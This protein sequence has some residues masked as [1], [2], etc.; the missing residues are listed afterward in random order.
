MAFNVGDGSLSGSMARWPWRPPRQG[1]AGLD[2]NVSI[3][4]YFPRD[5]K[6]PREGESVQAGGCP[7]QPGQAEHAVAWRIVLETPRCS[8]LWPQ[9][10]SQ[11][12]WGWRLRP[13]QQWAREASKVQYWRRHPLLEAGPTSA[14][15]WEGVPPYMSLFRLLSCPTLA[16]ALR[17]KLLQREQGFNGKAFWL[18]FRM[19]NGIWKSLN[20]NHG[21][22]RP[23]R[24][25]S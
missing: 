17:R 19:E 14:W 15:T 12:P 10:S 25:G 3:S 20:S 16:P 22:N 4:A 7:V 13:G 9:D 1:G 24:L 23:R 11:Q 21:K 2:S 6:G 5:H 18:L 8:L